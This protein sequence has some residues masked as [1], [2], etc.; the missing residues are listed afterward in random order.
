ML[1][2]SDTEVKYD[3]TVW[4]SFL[5]GYSQPLKEGIYFLTQ[6][7]ETQK[8]ISQCLCEVIQSQT[9]KK[10]CGFYEKETVFRYYCCNYKRF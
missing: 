8:S 1:S 4:K 2:N 10:H 9:E 3:A 6:R 5:L 7:H